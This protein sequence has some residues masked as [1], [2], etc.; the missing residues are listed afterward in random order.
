[1]AHFKNVTVIEVDG[2][3]L[4]FIDLALRHC[5]RSLRLTA[6]GDTRRQKACGR[7][8]GGQRL[9]EYGARLRTFSRRHDARGATKMSYG[10][11]WQ[12]SRARFELSYA[13]DDEN[14]PLAFSALR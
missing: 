4:A 5:A 2:R 3:E 7:T 12:S 8:D 13:F 1:M 14:L 11:H 6:L 9:K 10:A